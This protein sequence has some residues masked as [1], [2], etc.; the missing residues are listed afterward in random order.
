MP[1]YLIELETINVFNSTTTKVILCKAA[2]LAYE[3]ALRIEPL[4]KRDNINSLESAINDKI[5]WEGNKTSFPKYKCKLTEIDNDIL[6]AYM[7]QNKDITKPY[8]IQNI[9]TH[10]KINNIV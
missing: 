1:S 6:C 7:I 2:N 8:I 9:Y 4:I 10:L 5:I 3:Y